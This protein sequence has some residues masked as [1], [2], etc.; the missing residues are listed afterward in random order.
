MLATLLLRYQ[1]A[2]W[3]LLLMIAGF[4][5]GGKLVV[6]PMDGSHW[7][8]MRQVVENLSQRGHEVVVVIPQ[9]SW[10]FGITENYTVKTYPV[11][12]TKEDLDVSLQTYIDAHLMEQPFPFNVLSIYNS[13]VAVFNLLF[14][15][16]KSLFNHRELMQYLK[17]SDFD[18]LLTDPVS[19]CGALIANYFSLPSVFFLRGLPCNLHYKANRCPDPL[20]YVPRI[21][22]M[23]SDYMTFSQRLKNVLIDS[24]EFFYCNGFYAQGL[25]FA[26]E[27]LQRDVTLLDLLSSTS[28]WLMRYDFVFEYPRP[29]MPNMV[30]VGGINCGERKALHEVWCSFFLFIKH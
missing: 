28:I 15:H 25:S 5:E 6:V 23:N 3:T 13:S 7:L 24:V 11:S 16:C 2:A 27:V 22:T 17:Q 19:L 30:F 21:F 26:S 18:A 4:S 9:V 20:S 1:H 12:Y 14:S 10:Q 29:V 8:S